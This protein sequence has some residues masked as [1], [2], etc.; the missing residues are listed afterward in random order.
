MAFG[1]RWGG[2]VALLACV[3]TGCG[4]PSGRGPSEPAAGG[5]VTTTVRLRDYGT[6]VASGPGDRVYVA[7]GRSRVQTVDAAAGTITAETPLDSQPY[8]L[9]L[10]PDGRKLYVADLLGQYVSVIDTASARVAAR[11]P[12]DTLARPSLAPSAAASRDGRRVY[13]A[14][15]AHDHLLVVATDSDS[16][17][18][19]VFLDIHPAGIAVSPDGRVVYIAGCKLACTDG[20]LLAIDTATYVVTDRIGLRSAASGLALAPDGRR[21]YA[22]NGRDASVTA[23]DLRTR[24]VSVVAVGPAPTGI[25]VDPAGR[26]V[27][28]TSFEGETLQAIDTASNRVVASAAVGRGTRAVAVGADGRRAYLTHSTA[29]LS[30][31]D[32]GRLR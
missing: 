1:G 11:I 19:D 8:A 32:L 14:D 20:T 30:I 17:V 21:A 2:A 27:Y 4:M 25:A 18:K 7:V 23:I 26:F 12:V 6:D 16:I 15:T 24:A 9:A 3:G 31:V 29:V 28:V 5:A 10:T 22:P 13:V